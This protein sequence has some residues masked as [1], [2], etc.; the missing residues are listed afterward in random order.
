MVDER[1]DL[2]ALG[3]A[4]SVF[5]GGRPLTQPQDEL[6]TKHCRD[7]ARYHLEHT[8]TPAVADIGVVRDA[9]YH[10]S[11]QELHDHAS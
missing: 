2:F 10:G 3:I 4:F 1:S 7:E 9:S 11:H 6:V 5:L 8:E